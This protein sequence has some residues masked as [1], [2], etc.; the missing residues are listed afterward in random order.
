MIYRCCHQVRK[1]AVLNSPSL[2]G[3]DFL[4]VLDQ[5]PAVADPGLR[6][7]T[8]LVH[9]LK[10]VAGLNLIPGNVLIQGG[11]SVTSIPI[12]WIK[13]ADTPP[14]PPWLEAPYVAYVADLPDVSNVLVIRTTVTGDFSP[15]SLCLVQDS[16]KAAEGPF[17]IKE[18]LPGFD[19]L[20]AEVPFSFKVE[21]GPD[22]DCVPG[23]AACAA[24]PATPPP[25]NYLAKDYGSFRTL[26]LDR[27]R[28]LLP[29]WTADSESDLGVVLAELM[30]YVGDR[31]SYRQDAV[32]TEAYLETARKRVS[33]CR[34]A[35]L[36]DYRVHDGCNART[37]MRMKV[38]GNPG[39]A[40][41]LDRTLTRFYT[42]AP[43]MAADLAVGAGQERD[44]LA[45]GAVVFEPMH[46]A[47]LFPEHNQM[48]FY[49]WGNT[50]CCLPKGATEATLRGSYPHL[51][52]G[53]VLVFQEVKG[54]QTGNPADADIAHRWAVRLT[55]VDATL[56]DPLFDSNGN[57]VGA[58]KAGLPAPLTEIQWAA[59][60][61]PPDPV[62]LSSSFL[63]ESEGEHDLSDVTVVYGNVVLADQG[64]SVSGASLGQVPAPR[65]KLPPGPAADCCQLTASAWS[66]VRFRPQVPEGPLTQAA[67]VARVAS[68]HATTPGGDALLVPDLSLAA[69]DLVTVDL[70]EVIPV[71][72]LHGICDSIPT[73]W[74]ARHDLLEAGESDLGFVV[75]VET[76][77]TATLR[78]GDD[79]NG[80]RPASG[81]LFTGDYRIGN[82]T[83]GNVGAESLTGLAAADAR[84]QACAN[85]LPAV[86]GTDLETNDQIRRRAPRNLF[87]PERV[88]TMADY[89]AA[90]EK[91]TRVEQA[92]ATLRW[93][94][95][96][97]TVFLAVEPRNGGTLS[98]EVASSL[99]TSL[100]R[101]RLAGQDLELDSPHYLSLEIELTVCLDP[102]YLPSHVR[103]GL[104]RVL[105]NRVL[106]N[107]QKGLFCPDNFTFGQTVYLSRVYATARSVPGVVSVRA[108]KFQPQ[109]LDTG[110]YLM[111]GEIK[112]GALQVARLE[113]N[114]NYPSHGRLTLNLQ[115]GK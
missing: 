83:A 53:D 33:L 38:A 32:A 25:I 30:A 44:A 40:V 105:G 42:A 31:L 72:T 26:I 77:G 43:G 101:C 14:A 3:I 90:A 92:V 51:H 46:D 17:G 35:L 70:T 79:T 15:Y 96:W 52:P 103:Q 95:S 13:P 45:A 97:H 34:H 71:I 4:E 93:T 61:A 99:E 89:E 28:Q 11:E 62:C 21:C 23:L 54:P 66:P 55:Q 88:V 5:F 82:G 112:L 113:N 2:N 107:G 86:G 104:L 76:D 37:W 111:A 59:A 110:A 98:A 74:T 67:P 6:Q 75:Q 24:P 65:V 80:K 109:G 63:D 12:Q 50:N 22:F 39:A 106:P 100:D 18:P 57:P 1:I 78:F 87:S 56:T 27:L 64:L 69:A 29:N 114:P 68:S 60:D 94:G 41:F 58:A 16:A 9:C 81:T 49:T 8:L 102:D 115:G 48:G 108:T 7:R 91:D 20:L 36:V 73:T 10:P 47:L 19:P 85:P 84:I